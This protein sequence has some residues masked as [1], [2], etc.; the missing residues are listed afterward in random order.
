MYGYCKFHSQ[1][2]KQHID[3]ICPSFK[4][5]DDN[6]CVKRHP[7]TCKYFEKNGKCRFEKCSY[8]HEKEGNNLK[9]VVLENQVAVLRLEIEEIRKINQEKREYE[10]QINS[11]QFL[12]LSNI[13]A[14]IVVRLSNKE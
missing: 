8:S 10:R 13:I 9:V 7:K 14:D 4:D 12:K 6:G 2:P 1:W 5:C 3:G 11:D